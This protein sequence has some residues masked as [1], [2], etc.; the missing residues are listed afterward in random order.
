M[1]KKSLEMGPTGANVV[2]VGLAMT[3]SPFVTTREIVKDGKMNGM[4]K[5]GKKKNA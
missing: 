4:Q 1:K 5:T 3:T 2:L